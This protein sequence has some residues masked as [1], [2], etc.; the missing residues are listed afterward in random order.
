VPSLAQA[1]RSFFPIG[2]AVEPAV[3]L[4]HAELLVGQVNGLVAENAMKWERIHPFAGDDSASYSYADAD[5]IS[6][7]AAAHEMKLRGHTLV[8]HNQTPKWV[9]ENT[10]GSPIAKEELH[11][12]VEG[13]IRNLLAHFRGKIYCWDVVNEALSDGPEIWRTNSPWHR[14][15]GSDDDGD[16]I[17]GYI[18]KA[19]RAARTAD[20]AV[21]LFY[22]DYNIDAG[23]K[24]EKAAMLAQKLKALGLIDGIGIQG[25]WSLYSPD[26][27]SVRLAIRRFSSLGLEV[28]ITELD[29][30]VFRRGDASS[31]QSLPPSLEELQAARY[32]ALFRVFREEAAA[33]NLSGVTFWGIADDHTWLDD[34][35]VKSRKDW[36]LPFDS[37]Q[38]PKKAF[39][40]ITNW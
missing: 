13:H 31:L 9:F 26:E 39:K 7:F 19:F 36:P 33:G 4:S 17:P 15:A 3:I 28:Q 8:W 24:L 20:P 14:I 30:S 35:P 22:N 25:H 10:D 34:F 18:V 1:Y 21:K 12:R 16:G 27:E 32:G 6:D 29:L 40:A 5:A 37:S 38:K 23:S 2:A 11:A